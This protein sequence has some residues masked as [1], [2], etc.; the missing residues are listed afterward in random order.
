MKTIRKQLIFAMLSLLAC[1][2]LASFA[3][4][5]TTFEFRVPASGYVDYY[6]LVDAMVTEWV[7]QD[8]YVVDLESEW[9]E[10]NEREIYYI[11]GYWEWSDDFERDGYVSVEP[12]IGP[13]Y[14]E[15]V[16]GYDYCLVDDGGEVYAHS[17]E[18]YDW[19]NIS[20]NIESVGLTFRVI[21]ESSRTCEV[22]EFVPSKKTVDFEGSW[23]EPWLGINSKRTTGKR[24]IRTEDPNEGKFPEEG[25]YYIGNIEIP[26]YVSLYVNGSKVTYKVTGIA[27]R[28]FQ[29]CYPFSISGFDLPETLKTIGTRAFAD[30][31]DGYWSFSCILP[32]GLE[33]I[34]DYAF[35]CCKTYEGELYIPAG[36][37]HIGKDA[38][39][40][41][42]YS[43][44]VV[45]PDNP[46]YDSREDC[47]CLIESSTSTLLLGSSYSKIPEGITAIADHAFL[48]S[49]ITYIE[50]PQ[51][52]KSIG[53]Y[54]FGYG[55]SGISNILPHE[56][57]NGWGEVVPMS[58]KKR[59]WSWEGL[60]TIIIPE[61]VEVISNGAFM[62]CRLDTVTSMINTPF[63][64]NGN[65]FHNDT[66]AEGVLIVP[67]SSIGLYSTTDGWR[68]FTNIEGFEGLTL[69]DINRDGKVNV[70]DLATLVNYIIGK[71]PPVF[72][73]EAANL[74]KDN[75]IN[76]QDLVCLVSKLMDLGE[77]RRQI[78]GKHGMKQQEALAEARVCC[79][80]NQLV[81]YS[82]KDI[83]AFDIIIDEANAFQLSQQLRERG[84]TCQVKQSDSQVHLIGYSLSRALL[85][86]GEHVIGLVDTQNAKVVK[87]MLA[88]QN[89]MEIITTISD[90]VTG[91]ARQTNPSESNCVYQIAVG[92]DA[93]IQ[94]NKDGRKYLK[95]QVK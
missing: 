23:D 5:G 27:D 31:T 16:D 37:E 50:L 4:K 6:D 39:V 28:A 71:T 63:P 68:S 92:G 42:G 3:D 64:I 80:G 35:M 76:V 58:P 59:V 79:R 13:L 69:G 40:D 61:N 43:K 18:V 66:K 83:S 24:K 21:D 94:I 91:I 48:G 51:S 67:S 89:A 95:R 57:E 41:C 12:R 20:G 9:D 49:E 38:F 44:I 62:F 88:D 81:V 36:L 55:N 15:W 52:L 90:D 82:D 33:Y 46:V 7:D 56:R 60:K 19:M 1:V 53:E 70:L 45:S 10:E 25:S 26:E 14:E 29:D 84:I 74:W 34:G 87:A 65:V 85:P 11:I 2:P 22:M 75:T 32:S 47:N 30:I 86:Q 54:A 72:N 8:G 77:N 73:R 78:A 93:A 17:E